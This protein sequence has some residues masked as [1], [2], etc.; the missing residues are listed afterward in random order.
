VSLLAFD[1]L[2]WDI[3]AEILLL[4]AITGASY[5]LLAVGLVLVHRSSR[6]IN[7]AHA[8]VGAFA[9]TMLYVGVNQWE[10]PYYAV[11]PIALAL[12][13]VTSVGV[14]GIVVGRLRNAP[15]AMSVVA[16]LGVGQL[17]ATLAAAIN[18][19]TKSGFA[20]PSP[21]GMP[22][23]DVGILRLGEDE[24]ATLILA[25]IVVAG[26]AWFLTRSRAGLRV[27]A[28][29]S[30][31]DAAVLAGVWA[32][33]TSR[34]VWALAGVLAALTAIL[35]APS[36][37]PGFAA[38][39][40]PGLLLRGLAPALI[41]RLEH[42]PRAFAAGIAVGVVEQ[43]V[44]WNQRSTENVDLILL[45]LVLG[46]LLL[47]RDRR[48]RD[49][50]IDS[51]SDVETWRPLPASLRRHPRVRLLAPITAGVAVV[52]AALAPLVLPAARSVT[53]ASMTATALVAIGLGLV[54]GLGGQLSL[55]HMAIAGTAGTASIVVAQ[56]TGNFVAG[57]ASAAVVG[58]LVSM[59]IGLPALRLRGS[60]L[61]ATSLAF[62]VAATSWL[63]PRSWMLGDGRRP[64]KPAIGATAID[65]ARSYAW[66]V[67]A[68]A[69]VVVAVVAALRRNGFGRVLVAVRDGEDVARS[70]GVA[71]SWR[72]VQGFVVSGVV[73]GVGGALYAHTFSSVSPSSFPASASID[74]A[75]MVMVGG[76]TLL[77][78]PVIGVLFVV[79]VPAFL[80][81]DSAGLA[82][83][84]LGL[85][86]L[87]VY[88][89]GGFAQLLL[90]WR[91][92]IVRRLVGHP[93]GTGDADTDDTDDTD[94]GVDTAP[95]I[96]VR[97][98]E[99]DDP[100][101][102][103]PGDEVVL[104]AVGL[105]K[106]YGGVVAVDDVSIE[107]H[108]GEILGLIGP[109][110]AGKTTL[111]E[112][113]SGFGDADAGRVELEGTDVTRATPAA[114]AR[115]GLVRSF[116]SSPLFPTMTVVECIATAFE[117]TEPTSAVWAAL[118]RRRAERVRMQHATELADRFGL[119]PF[120]DRRVSELSTGTRRICELACITAL[121][122]KVL[123]LDEPAA[124][125][126]QR[127]VEALVPVL[128]RLRAELDC[129]ILVI[130][131]DLPMLRRLSHRVVAMVSGRVVADGTMADVCAHPEVVSAYLGEGTVAVERSGPATTAAITV[132]VATTSAA[133]S[134]ETTP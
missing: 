43:V 31:R 45:A 34:V 2:G 100:A 20:F 115:H 6:I 93:N 70:F 131:H 80:P 134:Q 105:A 114:R 117:R 15:R 18:T 41:A 116:Q 33:R 92:A 51:W 133:T 32:G 1:A 29:A 50:G 76:A 104:R 83:T 60:Y 132:P 85:L 22:T 107:L 126:A 57:L 94:D 108:R 72:K 12:A 122:P 109:N 35:T 53:V 78:G 23:F 14:E 54:T 82:T 61:A 103:R 69:V 101:D 58:G 25:P 66:F 48:Q 84:K 110:G 95:S 3:R 120:V 62:A 124:G 121:R 11:L 113:V 99:G 28:A 129:S 52:L 42:L 77:A 98:S 63:L 7:F 79:G 19:G 13:A 21:P 97:A 90:P 64:T 47:M 16:T 87:L 59:V 67:L 130:E 27:R 40:G 86:V 106:R 123:L 125:L 96:A 127:E 119:R 81:L 118:G 24:T 49:A 74:V 73:A 88:L 112:L 5:G 56:H 9:A 36:K 65:D 38:A 55:G 89:P 102:H 91:D 128:Q 26:L 37:G 39:L 17:L 4:G 68:I 71:A 75:V 10:L 44:F 111:F 46:T 30:N 8:E